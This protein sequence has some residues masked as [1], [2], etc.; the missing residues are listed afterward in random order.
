MKFEGEVTKDTEVHSDGKVQTS[1]M[2]PTRDMLKTT[3]DPLPFFTKIDEELWE[4]VPEAQCITKQKLPITKICKGKMTDTVKLEAMGFKHMGYKQASNITRRN[5]LVMDVECCEM[6]NGKFNIFLRGVRKVQEVRDHEERSKQQPLIFVEYHNTKSTTESDTVYTYAAIALIKEE[7]A[8]YDA[9][10]RLVRY[11]AKRLD[12]QDIWGVDVAVFPVPTDSEDKYNSSE[13]WAITLLVM[14]N[15]KTY[16]TGGLK[17]KWGF[18]REATVPEE[19]KLKSLQ[20]MNK[21]RSFEGTHQRS[22]LAHTKAG[23]HAFDESGSIVCV[24][25]HLIRDEFGVGPMGNPANMSVVCDLGVGLGGIVFPQSIIRENVVAIG[26]EENKEIHDITVE[27]HKELLKSDW[28]GKV[29]TRNM[30][31]EDIKCYEGVTSVSLYDGHKPSGNTGFAKEDTMVMER[32]MA[33]STVTDIT[34]TKMSEV[35]IRRYEDVNPEFTKSELILY[36]IILNYIILYYIIS[37]YIILYYIILYYII[38]YY[39]ILYYVI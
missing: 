8:T 18:E 14:A 20:F 30:K 19:L 23:G 37:Y 2:A 15:D 34:S 9:C 38:L 36:Y 5:V 31:A 26:V 35:S 25:R 16:Q 24:K 21:V 10:S 22:K 13:E 33:T 4:T 1:G 11:Q 39:I 28:K 29:A 6:D 27:I 12:C 32:V 3:I 7:E 17:Y